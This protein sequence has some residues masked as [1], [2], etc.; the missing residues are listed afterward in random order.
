MEVAQ[1]DVAA[2]LDREWSYLA[3]AGI[4]RQLPDWQ[5]GEP[6]LACFADPCALL[7]F[8]HSATAAETDGPLLALLRVARRDRLAGRL[9]LQMLLPALKTQ[10]ERI[11]CP[12]RRRDELWELLLFHAWETICSYPL[13]RRRRVAANLAL[14]V[15]HET[16]REL[17]RRPCSHDH[18]QLLP[19]H[20]LE[21][22]AAAE[23]DDRE[24]VVEA[25][26]AMGAISEGDAELVLCTRVDG[27][28]LRLL[29]NMLDVSYGAL[30][31]RRQRAEATLRS[32][33]AGARDVPNPVVSDL[34][35]Y[36]RR[37]S[38]RTRTA[39]ATAATTAA[40]ATRAA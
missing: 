35:S 7:R 11:V 4:A 29:A 37:S 33:L 13:T 15:L 38:R 22:A 3:G 26:V 25:A 8:L 18:E 39:A 40:R 6:A 17:Q 31:K 28:R 1:M 16:T 12:A 10:S 21:S 32:T 36:A 34:V 24:S 30:R 14:Q 5:Q 27:I 23:L 9:L 2:Q 19:G 20:E